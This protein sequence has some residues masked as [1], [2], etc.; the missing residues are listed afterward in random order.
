MAA[1]EA[2]RRCDTINYR[3]LKLGALNTGA[4]VIVTGPLS[5]E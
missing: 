2:T 3:T 5:S 1:T 4:L